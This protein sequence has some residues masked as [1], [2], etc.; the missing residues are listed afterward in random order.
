MRFFFCVALCG[1]VSVIWAADPVLGKWKLNVERSKY[2]PGPAPKSQTRVYEAKA[3]GIKVTIR[4]VAEDGEAVVV[5]HPLNYDGKEQPVIGSR[6]SDAIALQRIDE[7]TSESVMKHAD[8]VIGTN[9]RVVALDGK[10]MTITYQ[11][12]DST[13][14][15]VKVTAVYDRQ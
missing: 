7:Y 13:G 15:Q 2:L 11:G 4:T 3:D 8:K 9:R 1:M 12:L 6:Q 10:T 14:R 5:E